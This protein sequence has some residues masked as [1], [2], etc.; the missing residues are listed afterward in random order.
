MVS[1]QTNLSLV[2]SV[3]KLITDLLAD[4]ESLMTP[5]A[6]EAGIQLKFES[7]KDTNIFGDY[8]KCKQVIINLVNNAIKYNKENGSVIVSS[9]S[10][11]KNT[12]RLT[13]ADTG[14]GIPENIQYSVFSAFNRLGQETSTIEG[15]GIGLVVTK[16]LVE[17]MNGTIGF[18]SVEGQG[19]T[20][21]VELPVAKAQNLE[22]AETPEIPEIETKFILYVEDNPT[23][24]QLMRSA[25]NRL[26]HSLQIE[27]TGELGLESALEHD[28]DL[29]LMD[30]NLPGMDGKEVTRRL[31]ES[32]RYK[33]KPSSP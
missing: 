31:R 17:L 20:F 15:T 1:F 4:V 6:R 28:F 3:L 30:I 18:E 16:D 9:C 14:I 11:E 10:T 19:S 22:D 32:E 13:I 23:N 29:I 8:T 2:K 7:E 25:F 21:W 12:F 26:P 24:Q 27:S 33:D 5:I